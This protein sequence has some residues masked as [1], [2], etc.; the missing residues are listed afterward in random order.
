MIRRGAFVLMCIASAALSPRSV[1]AQGEILE[2]GNQLYQEGDYEGAVDAYEIV[3]ASGHESAD[4]HYN[5]GNAYF[6]GGQL[7]RSILAWERALD[8]APGDPDIRA[9]LDLARSLTADAVEPL[10]RFWLISAWSWW[11]RLVP[12]GL[13]IVFVSTAWL[14]VTLGVTTRILTRSERSG[15]VGGWLAMSGLG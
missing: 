15:R 1:V 9:N 12:R 6:K 10:P 4:L 13:L 2:R 7:G 3:L 8:R 5:L 14:A 11:F